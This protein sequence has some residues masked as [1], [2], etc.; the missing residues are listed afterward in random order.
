MATGNC[1]KMD[2]FRCNELQIGQSSAELVDSTRHWW[3]GRLRILLR[4]WET[5]K[6]EEES[7]RCRDKTEWLYICLVRVPKVKSRRNKEAIWRNNGQEFLA[8]K[9]MRVF[10]IKSKIRGIEINPYLD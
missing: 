4:G 5:K 2:W 3:I 7:K 9:M 6:Y 1:F 8:L 10:K